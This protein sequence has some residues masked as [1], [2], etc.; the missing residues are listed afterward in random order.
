MAGKY[1]S[2]SILILAPCWFAT[3][4]HA[5]T[6]AGKP[7]SSVA[8]ESGLAKKYPLPATLPR[9]ALLRD[10]PMRPLVES[11]TETEIVCGVF[12]RQ[13]RAQRTPSYLVF[14]ETGIFRRPVEGDAKPVRHKL[15]SALYRQDLD[16]Q[17]RLVA[18]S[19]EPFDLP[20]GRQLDDLDLA[21]Y[22]LAEG[23]YAF[24]VRTSESFPCEAC[25]GN[26]AL[27]DVFRVDGKAIHPILSTLL[28]SE[29]LAIQA[30]EEVRDGDSDP[31]RI[32]VLKTRTRGVF[33]WAKRKQGRS[34][35]FKW[36][37]ERYEMEKGS[38]DPVTD[39]SD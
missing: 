13:W 30:H 9:D 28:W 10:I 18:K 33:D 32:T 6:D 20:D 5:Q 37:G 4:A 36:N 1:F 14:L 27:L 38:E 23:D 12:G 2:L 3:L 7:A 21:P 31:A 17:F 24:G 22:K 39:P 8:C 19:A 16:G 29:T 15:R 26:H 35:T 34:A 25:A 11:R